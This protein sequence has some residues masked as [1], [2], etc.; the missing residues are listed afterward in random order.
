MVVQNETRFKLF[1]N[2]SVYLLYKNHLY[3]YLVR[4]FFIRKALPPPVPTSFILELGCGISPMLEGSGHTI[5]TDVSWQALA[6][7]KECHEKGDR[8]PAVACDATKLPFGKGSIRQVICSEVL[9]H[10][11]KDESVLEEINR[12]LEPGGELLLTCP[13]REELFGFD[14]LFVGH[15]R[16]YDFE[17]LARLLST[18]GF[19]GFKVHAVLGSL[20]KW[21]ME[22]VTRF[23][24]WLK[25]ESRQPKAKSSGEKMRVLAW[26]FFPIYVCLNYLLAFCVYLQASS[27]APKQAVCLLIQCRKRA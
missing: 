3:N 2:D 8:I 12:I 14:D 9:E 27:L 5:R 6:C 24:S 10:I 15:C 16:R 26:V 7:S 23:F 21:V 1:F 20:E 11:E 25:K 4:R 19:V 17:K 13:M 22:R 18:K